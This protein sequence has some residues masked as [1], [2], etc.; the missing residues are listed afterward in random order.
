[1]SLTGRGEK[2]FRRRGESASLAVSA[3]QGEG[4]VR[5][6]RRQPARSAGSRSV[7]RGTAEIREDV[8]YH[9]DLITPT[10][11]NVVILSGMITEN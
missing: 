8:D 11:G 4:G 10:F 1:M 7:S 2:L 6:R 9:I 5:R 3:S